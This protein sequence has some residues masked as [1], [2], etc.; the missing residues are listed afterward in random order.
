MGDRI[1]RIIAALIDYYIALIPALIPA[2]IG[3]RRMESGKGGYL[4]II[5]AFLLAFGGLALFILRDAVFGGRSIGKRIFGLYVVDEQTL[6]PVRGGK[7]ALKNVFNLINV[8]WFVDG[9]LLLISGRTV[10][11]RISKTYVLGKKT[12]ERADA[13]EDVTPRTTTRSVV[14]SLI[15]CGAL[16]V[17]FV[18]LIVVITL[19]SVFTV[20]DAQKATPEYAMAYEYIVESEKYAQVDAED[21]NF[22]S[23]NSNGIGDERTATYGF[24]VGYHSVEV[25]LHC[26]DGEWYVC[27]ECTPFE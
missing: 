15:V 27:R 5:L 25:T 14:T 1:K 24:R 11:E 20:L 8:M 12:L 2:F 9:I 17:A 10:G 22:N 4:I 18:L 21:I 6:Q 16:F 13:G 3:A 26:E 7:A 19:I 23:Y